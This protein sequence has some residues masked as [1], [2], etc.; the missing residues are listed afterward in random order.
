MQDTDVADD[1][2]TFRIPTKGRQ[3]DGTSVKAEI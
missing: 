2:K 3:W 1:A